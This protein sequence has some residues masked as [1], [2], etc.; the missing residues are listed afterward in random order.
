NGK[1]LVRRVNPGDTLLEVWEGGFIAAAW[2]RGSRAAY[3]TLR[4]P[5]LRKSILLFALGAVAAFLLL[6]AALRAMAGNIARKQYTREL[7]EKNR[8]LQELIGEVNR[9]QQQLIHSEKLAALGQLVAGIAHELNNPIGFIYANLFQIRKYLGGIDPGA[10]DSRSRASLEKIDQ[11]LRDSQDGSIRI[12][13]IVQ[14]LRGLSRAGAGP[15][16]ALRKQPCDMNRLIDKSLLL[17]QTT[18]S[19]NVLIEKDY[20]DLP[21]VE[22]DETQI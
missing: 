4:D 1:V 11:A 15:G 5:A 22:A 8:E 9:T 21:M 2:E 3:S 18:F 7:V 17:A 10:L 20:G 13:D 16:A 6:R 14:N 12:R 19:K